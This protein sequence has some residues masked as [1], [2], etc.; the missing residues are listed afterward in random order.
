[1]GRLHDWLINHPGPHVAVMK[2]VDSMFPRERSAV[3]GDGMST[4]HKRCGAVGAVCDGV[5]RDLDGVKRVPFPIWAT[6]E[7]SGHGRFIVKAQGVEQG[8][9]GADVFAAAQGFKD[10]AAGDP[11]EEI[12]WIEANGFDEHI[13]RGLGCAGPQAGGSHVFINWIA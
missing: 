6:G 9:Q 12:V 1:M 5:I 2:D 13:E 10:F 8:W 7:V 4:L 11:V 3:F